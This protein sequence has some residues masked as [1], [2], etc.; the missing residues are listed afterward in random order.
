MPLIAV[1]RIGVAALA[2]NG[3]SASSTTKMICLCTMLELVL[4]VPVARG[5]K[6]Y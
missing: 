5:F 2:H 4:L 1:N 6:R 3:P